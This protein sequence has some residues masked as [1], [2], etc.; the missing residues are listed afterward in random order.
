MTTPNLNIKIEI[1]NKDKNSDIK[2]ESISDNNYQKELTSNENKNSTLLGKKRRKSSNKN[3]SSCEENSEKENS[4]KNTEE[5]KQNPSSNLF[6][7]SL[8]NKNTY[9]QDL[10]INKSNSKENL[11]NSKLQLPPINIIKKSKHW[12][13]R[14]VL[15]PNVFDFT[16]EIWL[17]KWCLIDDDLDIDPNLETM[18]FYENYF[19]NQPKTKD[20]APKKYQCSFDECSK[21]F[22]DASSL[23]K[24]MLTH[25]ERQYVCKHEGCGK[26]FLDNSKLRRHQLVHTG[27]KPFK[28]DLCGKKFSLDFNLKTHLR[29]HTGE[30]PYF[31]SY[32]GCDKRFTQSSNLTAHEKTHKE[33][34]GMNNNSSHNNNN[35]ISNTN[36]AVDS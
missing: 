19:E 33:A 11:S 30:K 10:D 12:E 16:K 3:L 24:H 29:T 17:Q 13:K 27:E 25:G 26:K 6:S 34:E 7:L 32:V 21:I 15:V 2:E 5:N 20:N 23:K 18:N 14:W 9:N 28:C 31:C 22:I 35:N 36:I 8:N 1:N 4:I